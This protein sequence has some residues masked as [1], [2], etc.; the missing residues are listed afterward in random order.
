MR[1]GG[2]GGRRFYPD[3]MVGCICMYVHFDYP[4]KFGL[5]AFWADSYLV[6]TQFSECTTLSNVFCHPS[7]ARRI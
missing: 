4:R 3:S 7:L 2:G 1:L 5:L 6:N